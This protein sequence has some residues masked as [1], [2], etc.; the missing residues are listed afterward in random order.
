[1]PIARLETGRGLGGSLARGVFDRW[2]IRESLEPPEDFELV[3]IISSDCDLVRAR[4]GDGLALIGS[5][6]V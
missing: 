3:R 6:I 4:R 2:V 1:M 5:V